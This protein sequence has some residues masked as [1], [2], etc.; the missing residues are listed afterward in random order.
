[1][2][3]LQPIIEWEFDTPTYKADLLSQMLE[4]IVKTSNPL[5]PSQMSVRSVQF[6]E[7]V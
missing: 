5:I 1:M 2:K 4:Q 7:I 3:S 6:E